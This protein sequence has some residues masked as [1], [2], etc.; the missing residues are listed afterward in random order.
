MMDCNSV[1]T[2]AIAGMK[3]HIHEEGEPTAKANLYRQM[4]GFMMHT[5]VYIHSDIAFVANKL[6]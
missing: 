4:V 1:K 2:P 3:L 5:I 6:S